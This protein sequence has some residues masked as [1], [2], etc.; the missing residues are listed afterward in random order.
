MRVVRYLFVATMYLMALS[1]LVVFLSSV[2]PWFQFRYLAAPGTIFLVRE[3]VGNRPGDELRAAANERER[4]TPIRLIPR[5]GE[6]FKTHAHLSSDKF[7]HAA[8]EGG[9]RVLF[10]RDGPDKVRVIAGLHELD[11]PW[12]WLVLC[13]LFSCIAPYSRK[14]LVQERS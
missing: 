11:S 12:L 8:S 2:V 3:P 6:P 10:R 14:L 1:A 13:T 9:L 7:G 5:T 4:G